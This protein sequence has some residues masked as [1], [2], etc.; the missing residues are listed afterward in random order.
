MANMHCVLLIDLIYVFSYGLQCIAYMMNNMY[1]LQ[2]V[3]MT[4]SRTVTVLKYDL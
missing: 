2:H 3:R 4:V 1:T